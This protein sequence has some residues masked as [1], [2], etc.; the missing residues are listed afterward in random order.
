[1]R[2]LSDL[3]RISSSNTPVLDLESRG[4]ECLIA[5]IR[6]HVKPSE[7]VERKLQMVL[8]CSRS[9]NSSLDGSTRS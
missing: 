2:T 7:F 4:D 3:Q 8:Q 1:M 5:D 6:N 9:V